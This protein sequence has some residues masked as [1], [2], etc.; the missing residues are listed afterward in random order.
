MVIVLT[1]PMHLVVPK[2][3]VW[4]VLHIRYFQLTQALLPE[5]PAVCSHHLE[6]FSSSRRLNWIQ[7]ESRIR[8]RTDQYTTFR[9]NI[10]PWHPLCVIKDCRFK[11]QRISCPNC[12]STAQ[13]SSTTNWM[14]STNLPCTKLY[15]NERVKDVHDEE[16]HVA[17]CRS[18]LQV[19]H[20]VINFHTPFRHGIPSHY[21]VRMFNS[22][23]TRTSISEMTKSIH[24]S[25]SHRGIQK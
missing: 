16:W 3:K 13:I 1:I 8:C 10:S 25:R 12:R 7:A 6:T 20:R 19:T 4:C 18:P 17:N 23:W 11:G 5:F 9:V 21:I 14:L 2:L 15:Q 24:G 22:A